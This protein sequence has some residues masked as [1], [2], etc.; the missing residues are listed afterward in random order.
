MSGWNLE[1]LLMVA[2]A[3]LAY[4]DNS[5]AVDNF[6]LAMARRREVQSRKAQ[7]FLEV[8][9]HSV[10]AFVKAQNQHLTCVHRC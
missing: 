4:D 2:R 10:E 5:F 1:T 9:S 8:N 6:E 3:V 7:Y